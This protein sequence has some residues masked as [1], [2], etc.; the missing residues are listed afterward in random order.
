MAEPTG[1]GNNPT[2]TQQSQVEIQSQL[3]ELILQSSEREETL[4]KFR[5]ERLNLMNEEL[6]TLNKLMRTEDAI[7]RAAQG[8]LPDFERIRDIKKQI[9]EETVKESEAQRALAQAI[10]DAADGSIDMAEA[11]AQAKTQTIQQ[12][13][14]ELLLENKKKDVLLSALNDEEKLQRLRDVKIKDG[15]TLSQ[16]LNDDSVT[17]EEINDAVEKL[18]ALND[19]MESLSNIQHKFEL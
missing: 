18:L 7:L 3:N 16:M 1:G 12:L 11:L 4:Q 10:L 6:E 9:T 19:E 13:E 5:K 8:Q 14:N 17:Q 2:R 15:K